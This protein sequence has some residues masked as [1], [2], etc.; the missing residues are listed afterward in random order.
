ME[1]KA[2]KQKEGI[3]NFNIHKLNS[4]KKKKQKQKFER[5]VIDRMAPHEKLHKN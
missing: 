5:Y 4:K 3:I 2:Q 1:Y